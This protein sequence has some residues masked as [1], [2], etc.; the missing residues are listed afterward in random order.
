MSG[1]LFR[2]RNSDRAGEFKT[3]AAHV[4]RASQFVETVHERSLINGDHTYTGLKRCDDQ[5]KRRLTAGDFS[6]QRLD[7]DPNTCVREPANERVRVGDAGLARE[8]GN[9]AR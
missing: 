6:W 9:D 1:D 7:Q 3:R 4:G 8:L 2:Y 5:I